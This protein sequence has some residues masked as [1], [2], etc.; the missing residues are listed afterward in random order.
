MS[1]AEISP[2]SGNF[3]IRRSN[4]ATKKQNQNLLEQRIRMQQ[5]QEFARGQKQLHLANKLDRDGQFIRTQIAK[6]EEKIEAKRHKDEQLKNFYDQSM[7]QLQIKLVE[8]KHE[9]AGMANAR[10]KA[11][12]MFLNRNGK[13]N[14]SNSNSNSNSKRPCHSHNNKALGYYDGSSLGGGTASPYS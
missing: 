3:P 14:N 13:R 12:S 5:R 7:A 11:D 9:R 6:R 4:E 10:K 2:F 1:T 8:G